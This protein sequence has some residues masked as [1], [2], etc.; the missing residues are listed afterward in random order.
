M[1]MFMDYEEVYRKGLQNGEVV[2]VS[3]NNDW[4]GRGRAPLRKVVYRNLSPQYLRVS[5]TGET[6]R[7]QGF[8]LPSLK[9]LDR[10]AQTPSC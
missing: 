8:P 9:S 6:S 1:R 5:L 7:K 4:F 2:D 3:F 10:A